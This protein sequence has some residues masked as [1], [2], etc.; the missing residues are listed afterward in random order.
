M[1]YN[2]L[3]LMNWATGAYDKIKRVKRTVI[4][5]QVT[6]ACKSMMCNFPL[7][8][9]TLMI[10]CEGMLGILVSDSLAMS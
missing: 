9:P 2:F 6:L 10:V 1:E 5:F 3:I 7:P 4:S 8:S